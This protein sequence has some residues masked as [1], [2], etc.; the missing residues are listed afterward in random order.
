MLA[1]EFTHHFWRLESKSVTANDIK[2][3]NL[4]VSMKTV[5]R[6]LFGHVWL[7]VPVKVKESKLRNANVCSVR[8]KQTGNVALAWPI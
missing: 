5:K 6:D 1:I 4:T 8:Q 3:F 2:T 7:V